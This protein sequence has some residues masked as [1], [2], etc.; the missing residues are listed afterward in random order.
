MNQREL[1]AY[2]TQVDGEIVGLKHFKTGRID[3]H[4]Q[5]VGIK[6]YP[7]GQVPFE[8]Q[9]HFYDEMGRVVKLEKYE[10]E[11]SRPTRRL[12]FYDPGD[13]KV[14]ESV[15]ISRYDRVDNIHRYAYDEETGLMS[16]RAEYNA[17]GQIAYGIHS[18]YDLSHRL[19]EERWTDANKAQIKRLAYSYDDAGELATEA[20]YDKENR[21]EG[22]FRFTYDQRGNLVDKIWH[23]PQGKVMSTFRYECDEDMRVTRVRLYDENQQ[24][25]T[26]QEFRYDRAGNVTQET[27]KD[28]E[29]Q[30]VR[31]RNYPGAPTGEGPAPGGTVA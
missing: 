26:S 14:K 5:V 17:E 10:R 25:L 7:P 18:G 20:Q 30:V 11:F 21:P 24:L 29:G 13:P 2:L 22:F 23:N 31:Q 12:Y 27:W 6:E 15:W 1:D 16:Y 8:H 28:G 19:V 4:G 3:E 9:D